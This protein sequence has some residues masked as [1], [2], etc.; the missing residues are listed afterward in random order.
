MRLRE[1]ETLSQMR[2]KLSAQGIPLRR[3]HLFTALRRFQ[4]VGD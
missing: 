4:P 2:I 1:V 3:Y